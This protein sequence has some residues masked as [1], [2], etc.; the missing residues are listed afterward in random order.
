MRGER[1]CA[2]A[3]DWILISPWEGLEV[4]LRRL[5]GQAHGQSE[6]MPGLVGKRCAES[7]RVLRAFL[8]VHMQHDVL[9]EHQAEE[10]EVACGGR[11]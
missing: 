5:S 7:G 9:V 4:T 11:G 8:G 3:S 6:S 2:V 1:P 10:V